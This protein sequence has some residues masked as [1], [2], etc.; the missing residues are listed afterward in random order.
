MSSRRWPWWLVVASF[1]ASL[2]LAG[3]FAL[4]DPDEGRN[5]E[6]AREMM[7]AGDKVVPQLAGMPYLDK[8]PAL[9]W[10]AAVAMRALGATPF[11]ARLP[12]AIAAA[13]TLAMIAAL[14]SREV[15]AA[16]AIRA[17][18]LLAAAPL[19]AFLSAYVLFDMPLTFCVT[20][21]WTSIARELADRPQWARRALLFGAITIGV[22]LKGPVMLAWALGGS[23]AAA[24]LMRRRDPL[25]W[26]AWWPGWVMVFGIAGGWF[27]MAT[28]RFPEYPHYAFLEES[29]ERLTSGSFRREQP[30]WFVP[31]VLVGGALPWSLAT[32][33]WRWRSSATTS[34]ATG[35]GTAATRR[36][37]LGFVLFAV[38]FFTLSHSKLVTYLLPAFPPLAWL[39]AGAW[40]RAESARAS[41]IV[42]MAL[43]VAL[44]IASERARTLEPWLLGLGAAPEML[45]ALTIAFATCALLALVAV[46]SGRQAPALIALVAFTPIVLGIGHPLLA[47]YATSGSG[48]PLAHAITAA[49]A[50]T[51]RYEGCYSPGT[52]F[53]LGRLGTLITETGVETTSN[54]QLRYRATLAKR[55]Q[56][57]A[58]AAVT[59]GDPARVV[60]RAA[61]AA[62]PP[63]PGWREVF[64]DRRFAAWRIAD[65]P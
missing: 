18:A 44:A 10:A 33:W 39:A 35:D 56:W 50:N 45:R 41:A 30:W 61:D 55:G 25:R 8:P 23:L 15:D 46:G 51:V 38:V 53:L 16:F 62:A 59:P 22:L 57:T 34:G 52:D 42:L 14:A 32:P 40:R 64:H 4:I 2:W 5:A 48:A 63:E 7:T 54:Y 49:G 36:V 47:A 26:A 27:A 24:L 9:F 31:A 20:M 17:V 13:L 1:A 6:V 3:S 19:F 65:A 37:A 43:Y 58:R 60:V 12:A 11:A 28:A 21:V 29:F